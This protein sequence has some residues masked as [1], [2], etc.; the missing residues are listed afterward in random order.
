MLTAK[1]D[2]LQATKAGGPFKSF[3]SLPENDMAN[4]AYH[5]MVPQNLQRQQ[6]VLSPPMVSLFEEPVRPEKETQFHKLQCFGQW[7]VTEPS[8]HYYFECPKVRHLA[9]MPKNSEIK[10]KTIGFK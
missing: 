1:I 7:S 4:V 8:K 10:L 3:K 6:S 2:Q 5:A 9:K